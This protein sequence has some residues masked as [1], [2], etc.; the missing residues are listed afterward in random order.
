MTTLKA[1]FEQSKPLK[2]YIADMTTNQEGFN[3]IYNAF[4]MPT[5]DSRIE[6]IKQKPYR[7]VLVISEDWCGDAM[8]N[9][10]ILKHIAEATDLEVRVFYRDDDTQ[11]IDQY[12]TN[13]KSRSIPIFVFLNE[14]FEQQAV[15]GP[16]A[17]QVQS[18]VEDLRAQHLP[19]R[20]DD[21]FASKEKEVHQIIH[22]RYQTDAHFWKNVYDSIVDRLI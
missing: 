7:Y 22:N 16:R 1:Y 9:V 3:K 12:L 13:G 14:Q 2:Q 21:Q 4:D 10:P 5:D 17:K 8:M 11:L 18:F 19:D 6:A 20:S 15:W